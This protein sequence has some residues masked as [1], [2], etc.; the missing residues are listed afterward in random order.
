MKPTNQ[1]WE[2]KEN[3]ALDPLRYDNQR[4]SARS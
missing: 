3:A 2:M 1:I 4:G